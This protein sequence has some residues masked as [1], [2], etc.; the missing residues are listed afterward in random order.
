MKSLTTRFFVISMT[1]II[2][3]VWTGPGVAG[4]A[5]PARAILGVDEFMQHV[6][7]H[8]GTVRVEG[9]VSAVAPAQQTLALIDRRE[10]QACAVTTCARL[11][12]PVRWTGPMPALRDLVRLEGK[13]QHEGGKLIFKARTLEKVTPSKESR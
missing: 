11:T 4:G 13:V 9:V 1:L 8:R 6:E 12:L 7:Q 2:I 3:A 10:F 5:S